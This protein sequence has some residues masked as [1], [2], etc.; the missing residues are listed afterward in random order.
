MG[1]FTAGGNTSAN[2]FL[3]L[4]FRPA[5]MSTSIA[6]GVDFAGGFA[7]ELIVLEIVVEGPIVVGGLSVTIGLLL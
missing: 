4:G 6:E 1:L 2:A 5:K 3:W 7:V